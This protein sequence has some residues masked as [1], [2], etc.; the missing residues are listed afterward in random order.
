MT[1]RGIGVD[2][3]KV[4]R[5][6]RILNTFTGRNKTIERFGTKVLH[7][8]HEQP[9]FMQYVRQSDVCSSARLLS[10]SWCVKEAVFKSLSP[11]EQARFRF[12]DWYKINDADGRPVVRNDTYSPQDE[13]LVSVSHDGDYVVSYVLRQGISEA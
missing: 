1:V 6:H 3:V 5:F 10:G 8:V 13:F 12:R 11:A 2:I 9:Q 4:S 7:P